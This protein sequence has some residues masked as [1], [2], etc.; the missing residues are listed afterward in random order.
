MPEDLPTPEKSYQQLKR[1]NEKDK[2]R[3][4]FLRQQPMLPTFNQ[5]TNEP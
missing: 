2:Q 5:S 3:Q 1:E 4:A